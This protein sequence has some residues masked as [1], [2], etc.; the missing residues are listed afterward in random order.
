MLAARPVCEACGREEAT[1]VDHHVAKA[2]GG[3]DDE[4]NLRCYCKGCHS[5]KTAAHDGSFGRARKGVR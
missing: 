5:A 1:E 3:S 2:L 4:G